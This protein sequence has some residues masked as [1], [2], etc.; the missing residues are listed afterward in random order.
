MMSSR[1]RAISILELLCHHAWGL[2]AH[3][4]ADRLDIPFAATQR[5]LSGLIESG[6]VHGGTGKADLFRLRVKLP[7]LG[8]AYLGA[9]G[10]TDSTSRPAKVSCLASSAGGASGT[11]SLSQE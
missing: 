3:D 7:A 6:Y 11:Y 2:S 9:T 8:L 1:N 4:I 10:V 5:L